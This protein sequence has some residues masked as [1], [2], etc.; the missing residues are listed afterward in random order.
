MIQRT[1]RKAI[2]ESILRKPVTLVTGPRQVGKTT[3]CK[4]IGDEHGFGYVSL[5]DMGNREQALSDPVMFLKSHPAPLV[6]DEVQYAPGLFDA[7]EAEADGR[8]AETGSN[9]GMYLIIGSQV[10]GLMKGVTQSM[11][12][13]VSV[14]QMSPLSLS[15]TLGR[16]EVPFRVDFESDLRRAS[17]SKLSVGDIYERI[18]RGSYPE[19]WNDRTEDPRD[20]YSDYVSAYIESDAS[21]IISVKDKIKFHQFLEL[22]AS[23]SGQELVYNRI[24]NSLGISVKTAE[25]WVGVLATGGIITL[26]EPYC[27]RSKLKRIVRRPKMYFCD[28]GLAC[29]LARVC[30]PESLRAGY[31]SGHFVETYIVNE[32]MKSCKNNRDFPGLYYYRDSEMNEIDLMIL[33]NGTFS[34]VECKAGISY[35]AE[36]VKAFRKMKKSGFKIGHSCI[37]CMTDTGYPVAE[38]VYALPIASI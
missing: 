36:D 23:L 4:A 20:F 34:L 38:N 27:D 9:A 37:I 22:M 7:L 26:L 15:E 1:D 17:E 21:Q 33:R 35:G 30:D 3:L 2:E 18:F 5:A 25:S 10:Y 6:I 19:L 28:T 29:F 24:S 11:A 16:E 31:L 12:G 8:K 14:I 32:I 13:R